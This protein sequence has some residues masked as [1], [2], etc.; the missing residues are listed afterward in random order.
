MVPFLKLGLGEGQ[1]S[2]S[3]S[4]QACQTPGFFPSYYIA[5]DMASLSLSCPIRSVV[6]VRIE[7]LHHHGP[8]TLF[9]VK[10]PEADMKVTWPGQWGGGGDGGGLLEVLEPLW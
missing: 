10:S 9:H 5:S 2:C 1:Q 8:L 3:V 7:H 6:T 4:T